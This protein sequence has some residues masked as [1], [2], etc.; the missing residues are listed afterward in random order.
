MCPRATICDC[1]D[2]RSGTTEELSARLAPREL[3]ASQLEPRR[4]RVQHAESLAMIAAVT[5]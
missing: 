3:Y 2:G 1:M 4:Y 5:T